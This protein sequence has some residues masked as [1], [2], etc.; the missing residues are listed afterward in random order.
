MVASMALILSQRLKLEISLLHLIHPKCKII[1]HEMLSFWLW[2]LKYKHDFP[3]HIKMRDIMLWENER[4]KKIVMVMVEYLLFISQTISNFNADGIV[5]VRNHKNS[6]IF[7]CMKN[8]T[9]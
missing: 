1:V 6:M 4:E 2:C 5:S 3:K 9:E 8:Y 7:E